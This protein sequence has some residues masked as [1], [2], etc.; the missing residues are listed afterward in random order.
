MKRKVIRDRNF[1]ENVDFTKL[2]EIFEKK[3]IR[4]AELSKMC[5]YAS[6]YVGKTV[7]GEKKL[8]WTV[9]NM[10]ERVYGISL[11][12]YCYEKTETVASNNDTQPKEVINPVN[13]QPKEVFNTED[14]DKYI[15]G[16]SCGGEFLKKLAI[17]S[18]EEHITIEDFMVKCIV[19]GIGDKILE[20]KK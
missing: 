15:V 5:G 10:L 2:S 16:F 4:N 3:R 18:M 12:E 19:E 20:E 17:K 6:G 14:D 1:I 9:A 8:N 11:D 7:F 13:V